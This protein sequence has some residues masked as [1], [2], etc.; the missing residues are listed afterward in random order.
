[1]NARAYVWAEGLK[2]SPEKLKAWEALVPD[3]V[4]LLIWCL[5][6]EHVPLSA[7]LHW[8]QDFYGLPV[9][10]TEFFAQFFK[11][12][13]LAEQRA[14]GLWTPWCYPV[15]RWEDVTVVACA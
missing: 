10:D 3:G 13:F 5:E 6:Q 14:T 2:I 11:A 9:L 12:S 1:M 8:A 7:Y 4:P 15:A